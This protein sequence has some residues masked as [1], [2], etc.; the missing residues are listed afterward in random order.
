MGEEIAAVAASHEAVAQDAVERIEVEYEVLEPVFDAEEALAPGAP[1]VHEGTG[2]IARE[3]RI[4]H[5]DVEQGFR[6]SAVIHEETYTTPHQFQTYLEPLGALADIDGQG[7]I[8]LY[9]PTQSIYFT[10]RLIAGALDLPSTKIRVIQ[11]HVGGA[12]GGKLG[13]DPIGHIAA[14]LAQKTGR[15]VR[16]LNNRLDEFQGSRPR[17]PRGRSPS[18]WGS[19]TT[20]P[21]PP[22]RAESSGTNG[23]Y[24][25][26]SYEVIQVTATRMDNLYRQQNLKT[27]AFL[28]YTNL[29]PAGAFRGFGNPQMSFAMESHMD[30]LA[31]KLG[32]DPAELRLRNVVHQGDTSIHGWEMG[33]CGIE[34][35]IEKA[36]EAVGWESGARGFRERRRPDGDRSRVRRSF[37]LPAG[38]FPTG[39]APTAVVKVDDDGK[40]QVRLRRGGPGAGRPDGHRADRRR[41]AGPRGRGHPG[42]P[43]PTP[44]TRRSASGATAAG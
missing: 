22:R 44:R 13:E 42:L 29:I 7:R 14:V 19:G 24:S 25:G 3:I 6:E 43:R 9:V 10:R 39:T 31:E 18:R 41:R 40:A 37:D 26:F 2:N 36:T 21:S 20:G 11:T 27:D 38:S 4:R 17:M 35:C 34:E 23:A 16:L 12:F 28:V 1:E 15:P 32:M 8:T 5:G 33:S 30:V